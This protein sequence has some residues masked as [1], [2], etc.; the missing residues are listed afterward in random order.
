MSKIRKIQ[1]RADKRVSDRRKLRA[2]TPLER[3]LNARE[4]ARQEA[5]KVI[6]TRPVVRCEMVDYIDEMGERGRRP[7]V[8]GKLPAGMAAGVSLFAPDGSVYVS[9][10][11]VKSDLVPKELGGIRGIVAERPT[12]KTYDQLY[13]PFVAD[14]SKLVGHRSFAHTY[15]VISD[16]ISY[17]ANPLASSS[18]WDLEA[19]DDY[20][21]ADGAKIVHLPTGGSTRKP[22]Y[23]R[24]ITPGSADYSVQAVM[25]PAVQSN[26]TRNRFFGV[27]VRQQDAVATH[28]HCRTSLDQ[29]ANNTNVHLIRRNSGVGVTLATDILLADTAAKTIRIEVVGQALVAYYAGE[30]GDTLTATDNDPTYKITA[31][32]KPGML[33]WQTANATSSSAYLDD[34]KYLTETPTGGA[35]GL[36][37]GAF[38]LGR[39]GRGL[40]P[41]GAGL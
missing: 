33:A 11:N 13:E 34:W 14:L 39:G 16:D 30:S 31:A 35:G 38:G 9:L 3:Q 19:G 25:Q 27:T 18:L 7:A 17:T 37:A 6:T 40:S 2:M 12:A 1:H 20:A 28:Y 36:D 10:Q 24:N 21:Q 26:P 41:H 32:G 4:L 5:I 23:S 8:F 29:G 15:E 22:D